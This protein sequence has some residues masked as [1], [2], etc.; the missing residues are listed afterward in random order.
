[1]SILISIVIDTPVSNL[2]MLG[3][4]SLSDWAH[5]VDVDRG[6]VRQSFAVQ[7]A[8]KRVKAYIVEKIP[9]YLSLSSRLDHIDDRIT[10][11]VPGW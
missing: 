2:L 1:M 3:S 11:T 10:S 6:G 4:S 9:R 5:A 7:T 8:Q